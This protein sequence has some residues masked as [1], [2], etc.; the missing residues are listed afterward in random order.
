MINMRID[1]S[2]KRVYVDVNGYIDTNE[3]KKFLNQF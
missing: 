2:E 3:S 1:G